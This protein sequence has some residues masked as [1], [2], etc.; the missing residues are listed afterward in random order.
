MIKRIII[1]LMACLLVVGVGA[2]GKIHKSKNIKQHKIEK[3]IK[4]EGDLKYVHFMCTQSIDPQ[5]VADSTGKS[6][7]VF[8]CPGESAM[9]LYRKVVKAVR[10]VYQRPENVMTGEAGK[11]IEIDGAN[12]KVILLDRIAVKAV[13]RYSYSIEFRD[14]RIKVNA[15]SVLTINNN[16]D[17]DD[18]KSRVDRGCANGEEMCL[19]LYTMI[20][21]DVNAVLGHMDGNSEDN[22]EW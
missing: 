3:I 2:Q 15:P 4:A 8:Q 22:A 17:Y 6:Y 16:D 5:L 9:Q 1:C 14:G 20:N 7:F 10:M 12:S 13:V 21:K 11:Y 18:I 19:L